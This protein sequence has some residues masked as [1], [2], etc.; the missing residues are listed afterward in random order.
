[1]TPLQRLSRL[2]V[3]SP[4]E[5]LAARGRS[6]QQSRLTQ[7]RLLHLLQSRGAPGLQQ[8][9]PWPS[10][11][12]MRLMVA[13]WWRRHTLPCKLLPRPWLG[14]PAATAGSSWP[15]AQVRLAM[16]DRVHGRVR[17]RRAAQTR[18]GT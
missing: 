14:L 10:P 4:M 17:P 15:A 6:S 12:N 11:Q 2:L 1:M 13:L 18:Q 7:Q 9:M 16:R 8:T 3:T 5:V